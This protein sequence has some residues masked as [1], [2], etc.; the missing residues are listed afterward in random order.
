MVD[1][2][3]PVRSERLGQCSQ[4]IEGVY[5]HVHALTSLVLGEE[6]DQPLS[7]A[8]VE[9]IQNMVDLSHSRSIPA[10]RLVVRFIG[11]G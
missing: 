8:D 7:A 5:T 2:L 11:S 1:N 3:D 10:R 6:H 4:S 9:G